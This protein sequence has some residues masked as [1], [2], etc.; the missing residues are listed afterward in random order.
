MNY[1]KGDKLLFLLFIIPVFCGSCK[2]N[3]L[4]VEN[5]SELYRQNYVKDLNSLQEYTTG[6]QVMLNRDFEHGIVAAYADLVADNLKP[7]PAAPA[8]GSGIQSLVLHYTWSQEASDKTE[9]NVL[10]TSKAMNG[11][12][13]NCYRIIRACSF[14]LEEADKYSNIDQSKVDLLKGQAYAI[15]ALVHFKLVNIFAQNYKFTENASHPGIPY[16][17]TSDVSKPVSRQTTA[18][19]YDNIVSDLNNAIALL[20]ENAS[21]IRSINQVASKA[22]LA[23]VYLFKEDYANAKAIAAE[24]CARFPLMTIGAGYPND[25]FKNKT[26]DKTEVLYQLTPMNITT[27]GTISNFIGRYVRGSLL[28]YRATNDIATILKEN[29]NDARSIWVTGTLNLW[30]VTK[31]PTGVATGL[32]PAISTAENSYYPP[33]IRSSE[34]YLTVAECA[35]K[36]GDENTARSYLDII[37]KRAYPATTAITATGPALID[38]IYKERRKELAFEGFRMFDLQRW[39]FN[40]HR[41]DALYPSSVNLPYPS[42]K[43]ISPLPSLDVNISGLIQNTDY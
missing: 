23:R 35:A 15:R 9:P 42:N 30:N 38:S 37:R 28:R 22:L 3:F 10:E 31:F 32:T 2:K 18:E 24:I 13:T 36:T 8:P 29:S 19:I 43:A 20:P 7:L 11:I 33:I 26:S 4:E 40:V 25:L 39:K 21:D 16:I 12:W 14:V 41:I 6:I 5:N 1:I 34:M 27:F 17:T